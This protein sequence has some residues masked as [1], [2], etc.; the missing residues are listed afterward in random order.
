MGEFTQVNEILKILL[1]QLRMSYTLSD[2]KDGGAELIGLHE[3]VP[4]GVSSAD[5][6]LGWKMPLTKL[7]TLLE[8]ESR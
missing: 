4:K 1:R 7:A 8:V 2:T 6:Q 5:N 3:G